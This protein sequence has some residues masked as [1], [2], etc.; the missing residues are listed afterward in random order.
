MQWPCPAAQRKYHR[1][2]PASNYQTR[3]PPWCLP[4]RQVK[5]LDEYLAEQRHGGPLERATSSASMPPAGN[6]WAAKS[7]ASS[8][9]SLATDIAAAVGSHCRGLFLGAS[10]LA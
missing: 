6:A 7:R 10:L 8:V 3:C 4:S 5:T 1:S 2:H 9:S